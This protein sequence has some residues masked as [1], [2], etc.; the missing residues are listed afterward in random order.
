MNT[1]AAPAP[2]TGK[3]SGMQRGLDAL[4]PARYPKTLGFLIPADEMNPEI[5]RW[6]EEDHSV[7]AS[8]QWPHM[9]RYQRNFIMGTDQGKPPVYKVITEFVWKSEDDKHK[10]RA[11]FATP[12]AARTVNEVLPSWLHMERMPETFMVPVETAVVKITPAP[13]KAGGSI[14]RKV[15]LLRR[16]GD[17]SPRQFEKAVV[18]YAGKLAALDAR[19]GA[20]V[21]F[22]RNDP[23]TPSPADAIVFI[24]NPVNG[25]LPPPDAAVASVTAVYT[26]DSRKSPIPE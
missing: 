10:A 6:Y 23:G 18:V 4:F 15:I 19:S 16:S 13:L 11:L 2:S 14:P 8:F 3:E 5:I 21:D 7:Y 20:S 9:L 12:A 22:V 25:T 24:D 26:V 1:Q 17:L